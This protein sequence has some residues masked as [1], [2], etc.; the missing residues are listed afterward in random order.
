MQKGFKR[1]LEMCGVALW[2]GQER[3]MELDNFGGVKKAQAI[4]IKLDVVIM[5]GRKNTM[6]CD[7][8]GGNDAVEPLWLIEIALASERA[9]Y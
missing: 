8:V 5:D 7:A 1:R 9:Q 6:N 3:V 4:Y 2:L